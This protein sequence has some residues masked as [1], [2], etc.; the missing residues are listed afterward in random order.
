MNSPLIKVAASS[1]AIGASIAGFSPMLQ[2]AIS[3]ESDAQSADAARAGTEAAAAARNALAAGNAAQAISHAERAV[4]AQPRSAEYRHLLGRAYLA[5]GRIASAETS[6]Q[7]AL[8]INSA[9]DRTAFNLALVQV[10]QGRKVDAREGLEALVGKVGASDLGL[11]FALA[12]DTDRAINVL[13][14]AVRADAGNAKARQNLALSYA[15]AGRWGEARVTAAQDVSMAELD[16]R[17]RE[18]A[19]FSNPANSWDQVASLLGV[20]VNPGDPGQPMRLALAPAAPVEAMTAEAPIEEDPVVAFA[21][22]VDGYAGADPYVNAAPVTDVPV[23]A[24]VAPETVQGERGLAR[25]S[26]TLPAEFIVEDE[27][28]FFAANEAPPAPAPAPMPAAHRDPDPA[29]VVHRDAPA[30]PRAA[31]AEAPRQAPP[32]EPSEGDGRYMVQIGAYAREQNVE[33]GWDEAVRRYGA[34]ARY[35]PNRADYDAGQRLYRLAFGG[36]DSQSA[37]NRMCATLRR[38]GVEC[39]VR[40]RAGDMPLQMAIRAAREAQQT[41]A[42][43]RNDTDTPRYAAMQVDRRREDDPVRRTSAEN[44][45]LPL[46]LASD[47][48]VQIAQLV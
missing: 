22:P 45:V 37:A 1:L 5:A 9:L 17:M 20:T 30:A 33:R 47:V 12:G 14:D 43:H 19:Q 16:Q 10:A 2:D 25:V 36:Y 27:Q 48:L 28:R 6:F 13:T 32:P 18:W 21:A 40:A 15:L 41:A 46:E 8:Q 3:N 7:D 24:P 38:N 29:P 23:P 44:G 42:V 34:L 35:T 4:E 26:G 31:R 39:F 11:A